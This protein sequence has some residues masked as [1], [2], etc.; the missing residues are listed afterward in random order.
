MQMLS[1]APAKRSGGKE[2]SSTKHHEK[3]ISEC[4]ELEEKDVTSVD[5]AAV[6]IETTVVECEPANAEHQG[7]AKSEKKSS[8]S[9]KKRGKKKSES[10]PG[11]RKPSLEAQEP[12]IPPDSTASASK[13]EEEEEVMEFK[14]GGA[15]HSVDALMTSASD[16]P[17]PL[18][19]IQ[20]K[21]K[22]AKKSPTPSDKRRNKGTSE[23]SSLNME[24]TADPLEAHEFHAMSSEHL[25]GKGSAIKRKRDKEPVGPVQ[26]KE[27]EFSNIAAGTA[28]STMESPVPPNTETES[29]QEGQKPPTKKSTDNVEKGKKTKTK[30]LEASA[31]QKTSNQQRCSVSSTTKPKASKE[32]SRQTTE[33]SLEAEESGMTFATADLPEQAEVLKPGKRRRGKESKPAKEVGERNIS[34]KK[35]ETSTLSKDSDISEVK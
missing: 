6:P 11:H 15:E 2:A 25:K 19:G 1:G 14:E 31:K 12:V 28:S 4:V 13:R 16:S 34:T 26:T 35:A 27:E 8:D 20:E 33:A 24:A 5:S 32:S 10:S 21:V 30:L 18:G 3:K 29:P 9:K 7:T 17:V 22:A 23:S